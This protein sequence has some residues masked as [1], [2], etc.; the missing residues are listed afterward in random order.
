MHRPDFFVTA[1]D[2]LATSQPLDLRRVRI[3]AKDSEPSITE[4]PGQWESDI[5]ES[6]DPDQGGLP[7]QLPGEFLRERRSSRDAIR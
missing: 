5:T 6:D 2:A 3:K 1:L 7:C 4:G